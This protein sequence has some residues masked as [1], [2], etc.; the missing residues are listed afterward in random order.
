LY[1]NV[2]NH[3]LV[4]R[5]AEACEIVRAYL[6]LVQEGDSMGQTVVVDGGALLM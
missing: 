3:L 6:F 2:G 1:A 5:L 4:G